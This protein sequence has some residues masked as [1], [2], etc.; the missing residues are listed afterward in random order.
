MVPSHKKPG[1]AFWATVVVVVGLVAYPLSFGPA[2]WITSRLDR[3]ADLIPVLYRPLTW[4]MS[5]EHGTTINRVSTWYA[6][7]GAAENWEW[8]PSWNMNYFGAVGNPPASFVGWMWVRSPDIYVWPPPA[9]LL[10][11]TPSSPGYSQ[12]P[13]ELGKWLY[14]PKVESGGNLSPDD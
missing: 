1:V 10:P 3:G 9:M 4:A 6:K 13:P 11:P 8:G 7:V 2:C 12:P 5:P 14:S